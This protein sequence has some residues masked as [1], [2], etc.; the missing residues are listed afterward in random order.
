[1]AAQSPGQRPVSLT[2]KL[3]SRQL[4]DGGG[5]EAG[6]G[7]RQGGSAEALEREPGQL[8]ARNSLLAPGL[9]TPGW[10]AGLQ[11]LAAN[12]AVGARCRVSFAGT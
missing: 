8:Q 12:S 6:A 4:R 9:Q 3:P 1:M 2:A 10:V 11:A 7:G 5:K